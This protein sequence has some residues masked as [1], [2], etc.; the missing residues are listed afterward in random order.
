MRK[1]HLEHPRNDKSLIWPTGG[2]ANIKTHFACRVK[3]VTDLCGSKFSPLPAALLMLEGDPPVVHCWQFECTVTCSQAAAALQCRDSTGSR[4]GESLPEV[5]CLACSSV[6][7]V[8]PTKANLT[9]LAQLTQL[10]L[11]SCFWNL[12]INSL[13]IPDQLGTCVAATLKIV[14]VSTTFSNCSHNFSKEDHAPCYTENEE[15]FWCNM[16][17]VDK[18]DSS[19]RVTVLELCLSR[20]AM[21]PWFGIVFIPCGHVAMISK[22]KK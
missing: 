3:A 18:G 1:H 16:W 20:A 14:Q 6:S 21:W 10:I 8:T 13:S 17:C 2:D 15:S 7:S 19:R 11:L 22:Q 5:W 4:V 12:H 9:S